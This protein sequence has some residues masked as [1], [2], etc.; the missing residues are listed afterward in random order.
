MF[1]KAFINY[2]QIT[3]EPMGYFSNIKIKN[4]L[5]GWFIVS[6]LSATCNFTKIKDEAGINLSSDNLI[7]NNVFKLYLNESQT[8]YV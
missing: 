5:S 1:L 6:L 4:K 2:L 7:Q 8:S 3:P